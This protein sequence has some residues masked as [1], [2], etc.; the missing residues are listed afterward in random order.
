[1]SGAD[2]GILR[3]EHSLFKE[4]AGFAW[5]HSPLDL[6]PNS[7]LFLVEGNLIPRLR[8]SRYEQF[9]IKKM[10]GRGWGFLAGKIR[11]AT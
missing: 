9:P 3:R 11:A 1:M 10:W 6:L 8:I 2:R 4:E 5:T 7:L